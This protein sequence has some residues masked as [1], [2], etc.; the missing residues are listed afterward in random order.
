MRRIILAITLAALAGCATP[1]AREQD[2][3]PSLLPECETPEPESSPLA[4]IVGDL[5]LGAEDR[6]RL[7]A[8]VTAELPAARAG[9]V[10]P[11]NE[12][13]AAEQLRAQ[14]RLSADGP[15]C[16]QAPSLADILERSHP[17]LLLAVVRRFCWGR[18]TDGETSRSCAVEVTYRR[19]VGRSSTCLPRLVGDP[20]DGSP[21]SLIASVSTLK[22]VG[23]AFRV[24]VLVGIAPVA[25]HWVHAHDPSVGLDSTL[26]E[27]R[28]T[29][30][31]CL[32]SPGEVTLDLAWTISEVGTTSEVQATPA[33][34]HLGEPV[35][36]VQACVGRVLRGL[37]WPCTRS[38]QP[39]QVRVQLTLR[40]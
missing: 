20:T 18:P 11:A 22:R 7:I 25:V 4:V 32:Q 30:Q 3:V 10:L 23:P 15:V 35:A 5:P 21:A 37:A 16:G 2:H 8:A 38:G 31:S 27:S 40:R 9:Y 24:G 12:V 26:Y 19:A 17:G 29:L 1:G 33:K 28:S 13:A 39:E 14:R 6:A 36:D 34:N